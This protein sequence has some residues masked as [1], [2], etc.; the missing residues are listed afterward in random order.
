MKVL[1][2]PISST[3]NTPGRSTSNT[4]RR[5][6]NQIAH[7]WCARK[8][9]DGNG[10]KRY[11]VPRIWSAG[12]S[13]REVA[14]CSAT[15]SSKHSCLKELL[16]VVRRASSRGGGLSLKLISLTN[17][18]FPSRTFVSSIWRMTAALSSIGCCRSAITSSTNGS[19]SG[20]VDDN[21]TIFLLPDFEGDCCFQMSILSVIQGALEEH[22]HLA[23]TGLSP[24]RA[25]SKSQIFRPTFLAS[26]YSD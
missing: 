25:T 13:G 24:F 2:R 22:T 11:F 9:T 7:I 3:S 6:I 4:Q 15:A 26:I 18:E 17:L 21:S 10:S 5:T 20:V 16:R 23:T 19:G 12:A 1:P 14:P 8:V